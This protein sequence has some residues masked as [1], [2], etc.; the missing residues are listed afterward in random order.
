MTWLLTGPFLLLL[1]S[2]VALL[3]Y[4]S[5]RLAMQNSRR[6]DGERS[7]HR[8]QRE[9]HHLSVFLRRG[10]LTPFLVLVAFSGAAFVL[11]HYLVPDMTL[12]ELF[13][14]YHPEVALHAPD[15]KAWG[16]AIEANRR[17]QAYREWQQAQGLAPAPAPSL[18]T[19]MVEH[20]TLLHPVILLLPLAYLTWF[21][22]RR[23]FAAARDYHRGVVRRSKRYAL[24]AAS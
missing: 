4:A 3:P 1:V 24:R 2:L 15:L 11:H 19:V 21:F 20:W 13:G 6:P 23:Y 5:L 17:D 9:H 18:A 22:R 10:V 7:T 14:E 8:T 12:S 16:E